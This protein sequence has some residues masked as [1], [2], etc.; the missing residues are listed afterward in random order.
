MLKIG[1]VVKNI[2]TGAE[3]LRFISR[4]GQFGHGIAMDSPPLG[5]FFVAALPRR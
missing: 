2:A 1:V 5:F 3:G 4:A